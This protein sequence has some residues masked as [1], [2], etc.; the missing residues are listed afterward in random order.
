MSSYHQETAALWRFMQSSK[1]VGLGP[2]QTY[3]AMKGNAHRMRKQDFFKAYK[4]LNKAQDVATITKNSNMLPGSQKRLKGEL[5]RAARDQTPRG[6]KEYV[7]SLSKVKKARY[8]KA[9]KKAGVD[10]IKKRLF[11]YHDSP[12]PDTFTEFTPSA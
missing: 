4:A 2:T 9:G 7:K 10:D 3:N 12:T 5:Y 1:S 6:E 8:L 11:K